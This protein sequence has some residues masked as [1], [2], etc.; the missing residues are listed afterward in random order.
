MGW[1]GARGRKRRMERGEGERG[2]GEWWE[3]EDHQEERV[4]SGLGEGEE[5]EQWERVKR[6]EEER[7]ER[8]RG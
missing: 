1:A 2:T 8:E 5:G 6:E 7:R 4:G 3:R